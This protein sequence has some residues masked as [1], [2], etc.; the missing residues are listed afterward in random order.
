MDQLADLSYPY[1]RALLFS[2]RFASDFRRT[3]DLAMPSGVVTPKRCKK[4]SKD[5]R[6]EADD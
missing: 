5:E 6:E 1:F 2:Q 4:S 3:Y